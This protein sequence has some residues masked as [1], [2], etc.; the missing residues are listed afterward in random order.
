MGLFA[1]MNTALVAKILARQGKTTKQTSNPADLLLYIA[2]KN[3]K[4]FVI[5]FMNDLKPKDLQYYLT[6]WRSAKNLDKPHSNAMK[7]V[8]GVEIDL[9]NILWVYR[10]KQFYKIYGDETYSYLTPIRYRLSGNTLAKIVACK[11]TPSLQAELSNTI[12]KN[13][14]GDFST[15]EQRLAEAVK[16]QYQKKGQHSHIALL[17]GY[18]HEMR[19]CR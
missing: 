12:Y 13:I 8:L 18:L 14:F 11:D 2:K 3:E 16:L 1:H 7:Q 10:L 15:P 17:C 6:I 9:Q 19:V 5:S 4:N